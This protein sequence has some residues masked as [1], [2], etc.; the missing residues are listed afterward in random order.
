MSFIEFSIRRVAFCSL[1]VFVACLGGQVKEDV[2]KIDFFY[3]SSNISEKCTHYVKLKKESIFD[4][5]F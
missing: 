5:F 1:L 2:A 3:F 4:I